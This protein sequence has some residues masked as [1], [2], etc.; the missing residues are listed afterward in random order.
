[1]KPNPLLVFFALVCPAFGQK[2]A[3]PPQPEIILPSKE[4]KQDDSRT[5]TSRTLPI[6]LNGLG[7]LGNDLVAYFPMDETE[8]GCLAWSR[9]PIA[10]KTAGP[11]KI[12]EADGRTYADFSEKGAR[13]VFDPPLELGTRFTLAG[14]IQAPA[15]GKNGAI[16]QGSG[17][18]LFLKPQALTYW[19]K[20]TAAD[21]I[22][23]KTAAP[24]NGWLHVA[25]ICDGTKTQA[26]L[27]GT[28][29]DSVPGIVSHNL[30]TVGNHPSSQHHDW[31]MAAGIDEQFI[32]S[33]NLTVD[34]IKKVMSFSQPKK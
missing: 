31:M 22:Y 21:G 3:V 2:P 18:L 4:K 15:P 26:F 8:K 10:V 30:I 29:L 1:M 14:W 33:R 23:A 12:K 25:V 5:N 6:S 17:G 11:L 9:K 19:H 34:E 13:L 20:K 24:L 7:L 28:A 32:F 16:W 27:N